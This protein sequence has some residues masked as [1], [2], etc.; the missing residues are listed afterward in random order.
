ML[1]THVLDTSIGRPAAQVPVV[2][3]ALAGDVRTRVATAVTN[4]DGRNERPLADILQL[5]TYELVFNVAPYF[6]AR[7]V[8]AFYDEI[9][10]RFRVDD[11]GRAYHVPLLLAPWGYSTYRG[12]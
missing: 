7:G 12:S 1:S 10:I 5:G 2:L 4:L 6:A 3:Y 11:A 8:P 9:A